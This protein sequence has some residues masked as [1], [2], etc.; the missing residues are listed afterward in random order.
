MA[1]FLPDQI[2]KSIVEH[3]TILEAIRSGDSERARDA[4]QVH[5]RRSM[6]DF[7]SYRK[8]MFTNSDQV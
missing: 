6:T 7:L 1:E 4:I 8:N 5:V 3:N 2:E